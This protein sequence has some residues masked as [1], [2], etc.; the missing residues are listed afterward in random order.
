MADYVQSSPIFFRLIRN[1]FLF[2]T[3]LLLLA[4][5]FVQAPLDVPADPARVPNPVKSAWFLLW[6]QEL[7]SYANA[8]IYPVLGMAL[9]FFLLPFWPERSRN[10]RAYWQLGPSQFVALLALVIILLLTGVAMFFRGANW[11]L[12]V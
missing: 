2:F 6:T 3:T 4:A 12:V 1:S 7:V 11:A 10:E 8:A 5:F 9:A